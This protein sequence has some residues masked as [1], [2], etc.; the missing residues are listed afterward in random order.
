MISAIS[1]QGLARFE[2]M[3]EATNTDLSIGFMERLVKGSPQKICLVLDNL[4]VHHDKLVTAWLA[5]RNGRIEV[6][7]PP[8]YSSEI[9]PDEYLNR[10]FKTAPRSSNRTPSK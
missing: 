4:R 9:N 6:F 10:D 5:E 2:F 7:Y 8:P 3:E 1:N